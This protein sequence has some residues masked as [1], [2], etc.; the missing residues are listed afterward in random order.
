MAGTQSAGEENFQSFLRFCEGNPGILGLILVGS[1]GKGWD[2]AVA[3]SSD[4]DCHVITS[5]EAVEEI[6][7]FFESRQHS[8]EMAAIDV[9]VR[10]LSQFQE[11]AVWGS[12][13]SWDRYDFLHCQLLIDKSDG[14]LRKLIAEKGT[15]PAHEQHSFICSRLRAYV[16]AVYHSVKCF[17][18]GNVVGARLEA[19][20]SI[21]PL[22]DVLFA[23][24][25]RPVPFLSFL[26][27]ELSTYPLEKLPWVPADFLARLLR[28][29][30]T[31]DL[32]TQQTTLGAV[33]TLFR[34]EGYA[35]LLAEFKGRSDG[36]SITGP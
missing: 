2:S 9:S 32:A 30:S 25:S 6:T 11:Y 28:I 10:S 33:E 1:R 16:N 14:V 19:A 27:K 21:F 3:S 24:H 34:R 7:Q 17:M 12:L 26:E 13:D 29:L 15:L 5:D 8:P 18:K 20:N 36:R 22:L 23:L 4:F 35:D 31:A